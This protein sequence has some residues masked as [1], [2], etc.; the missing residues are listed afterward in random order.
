[1]GSLFLS[2][3][4][5]AVDPEQSLYACGRNGDDRRRGSGA[6]GVLIFRRHG[7]MERRSKGVDLEFECISGQGVEGTE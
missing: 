5:R 6:D 1:M 3:F 7:R 4:S 2:N